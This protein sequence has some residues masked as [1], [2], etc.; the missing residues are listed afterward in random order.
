MPSWIGVLLDTLIADTELE[1]HTEQGQVL[2]TAVSE[3]EAVFETPLSVAVTTTVCSEVTVPAL[4]ANV[5]V[6][7]DADT[8]TDD[9]TVSSLL[10][11][12]IETERLAAVAELSVTVH[13]PVAPEDNVVGPHTNDVSVTGDVRLIVMVLALPFIVAVTIAD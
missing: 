3:T 13:V 11:S 9:G 6:E 7:V 2:A 10:V 8:V 1:S 5:A 12:E 4:A